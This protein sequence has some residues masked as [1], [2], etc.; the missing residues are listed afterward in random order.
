M[1]AALRANKGGPRQWRT[2][3]VYS[4]Q[5]TFNHN[6]II[7]QPRPRSAL[8]Y[9]P[10]ELGPSRPSQDSQPSLGSPMTES[11]KLP[12]SMPAGE[13]SERP[14]SPTQ[15][16]P[17]TP[18]VGADAPRTAERPSAGE[19]R[20][21]SRKKPKNSGPA[22]RGGSF[23]EQSPPLGTG[24]RGDQPPTPQGNAG[25]PLWRHRRPKS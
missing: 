19:D 13:P 5:S 14:P 24:G 9:R 22:K 2:S 25:D 18:A 7:R 17:A 23:A 16:V 1:P 10:K 6:T 11:E 15:S 8:E 21:W 4:A 20:V 12:P 3:R